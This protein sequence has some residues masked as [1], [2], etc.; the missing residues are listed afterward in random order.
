MFEIGENNRLLVNSSVAPG[1]DSIDHDQASTVIWKL[2][3]VEVG[4]PA[5]AAGLQCFPSAQHS[6]LPRQNA[7]LIPKCFH[8]EESTRHVG[9]KDSFWIIFVQRSCV[10]VPHQLGHTHDNNI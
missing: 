1:E 7:I 5:Q 2:V 9:I 8:P 6:P 4:G 3:G 10:A